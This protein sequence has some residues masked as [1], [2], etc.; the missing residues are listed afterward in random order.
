VTPARPPDRRPVTRSVAI[1][2]ACLLVAIVAAA[3]AG[4][5]FPF[6]PAPDHG[7]AAAVERAADLDAYLAAEE[8]LVRGVKPALR[9]GII[10]RDTAARAN[11][12][13]AIIYLHGFS[14]SRGELSPV[15][16]RV[17][18]ELGAN[19]FFTRLAAHGRVDGEAFATV[20]P[21]QWMDDAREALAIGRRIGN[22]VVIVATSTGAALAL[23]LAAEERQ[24]G[25]IAA[26]VLVS[27]N[28]GLADP[29]G[30]FVSGP[31]GPLLARLLV[32]RTRS[33]PVTNARHAELW[34]PT[35]RSE[36]IAAMSDLVNGTRR[37]DLSRI[38]VPVL[39]LYTR[40]DDVV[41]VGLIR[42]RH[43]EFGSRVKHIV[44]VPEATRHEMASDALVPGAVDPVIRLVVDFLRKDAVALQR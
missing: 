10:W 41:D 11:T 35:Y 16:E 22:R 4:P 30:Q 23:Q 20:T 44:D 31:L 43:D 33:F 8:A 25:S 40:N 39:T 13:V 32:G 7:V 42:S 9:K 26:L 38:I 28:H 24:P 1:G 14:A 5:L 34:T 2:V 12:P 17:G 18:A 19:L 36:G 6:R 15:V 3:L 29:R 27:P 21:Q 37:L